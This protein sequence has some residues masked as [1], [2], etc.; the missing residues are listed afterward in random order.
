VQ[1][2][3]LHHCNLALNNVNVVYLR[4]FSQ[5]LYLTGIESLGDQRESCD[6]LRKIFAHLNTRKLVCFGNSGGVFGALHC[7]AMLDASQIMAFGGPSSLEL[8]L[9]ETERQSYPRLLK[10]RNLGAIDWPDIRSIY[11]ANGIS[12][13]Y[14]YAADNRVDRLQAEACL[15]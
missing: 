15:A 9:E 7:G 8:G 14:Y 13:G 4:D 10:L 1:L 11:E 6:A 5:N 3:V 2:N 12:I